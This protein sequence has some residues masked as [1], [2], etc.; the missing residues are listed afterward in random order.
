[1]VDLQDTISDNK[2][3]R[4]NDDNELSSQESESSSVAKSGTSVVVNRSDVTKVNSTVLNEESVKD[5]KAKWL[6][7]L[8]KFRETFVP[9]P[10]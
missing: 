1:M 2:L 3:V 5:K 10:Q 8:K 7:R 6:Q 4:K 9:P